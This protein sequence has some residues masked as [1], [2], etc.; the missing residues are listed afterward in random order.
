MI[1]LRLVENLQRRDLRDDL[2]A[3]ARIRPRQRRLRRRLLLRIRIKNHRTILRAFVRALPVKRGRIMDLPEIIQQRLQRHLLRI[4]IHPHDF[5]VSGNARAH[6]FV[7][8]IRTRPARVTA[9][10]GCDAGHDFIR[11]LGAPKTPSPHDQRF[12]RCHAATMRDS[13]AGATVSLG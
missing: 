13:A 5:R 3:P 2:P 10:H 9:D 8:R 7:S 12:K 6:L 4:I 11:R 1:R